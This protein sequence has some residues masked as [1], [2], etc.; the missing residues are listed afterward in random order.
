MHSSELFCER[1]DG[2]ERKITDLKIYEFLGVHRDGEGYIFRTYQREAVAVELAG[3]FNSWGGWQMKN[4]GYGYW[5]IRVESE[6][7]LE[8]NCYKY[9]IYNEENCELKPDP[10]ARYSQWGSHDASIV[11]FDEYEWEDG[12]WMAERGKSS[13][14]IPLNIYQLHLG[15]WKRREGRSYSEGDAYLN[16]RDVAAAL[17]CY[18]SDMGYTHA[19]FIGVTEEGKELGFAPTA[20]YGRPDGLKLLVDTLHRSNIGVIFRLECEK[21]NDFDPFETEIGAIFNSAS[22]WIEE[23]HVDGLY[24][25]DT[26]STK[27]QREMKERFPTLLL[28][29][30]NDGNK[31]TEGI[32]ADRRWSRDVL[33]YAASDPQY[34]RFKYS[35]INLS[36][37]DGMERH[38]ILPITYSD[39]SKGKQ[40]LIN[41]MRGSY[42][43]KFDRLRLFY[44]YMMTHPGKKLTFMGCE[45]GE[46]KEWSRDEPLEWFLLEQQANKKLKEFVKSLNFLY[47]ESPE[48]WK[49]DSSWRGF[50]WILPLDVQNGI[51]AFKRLDGSGGE[52]IAAL[53]FTDNR[54]RSVEIRAEDVIVERVINSDKREYGGEGRGGVKIKEAKLI[55]SVPPLSAVVVKCSKN[56]KTPF[57]EKAI[58]YSSDV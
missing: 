25:A 53:N 33:D 23:Y 31:E 43:E 12:E 48:L 55:L 34:K 37:T 4:I 8:G 10:Y 2:N 19:G 13:F 51:M 21:V 39:I 44:C 32:L 35:R 52:M 20:R 11:Y 3:D 7:P 28:I 56:K 9:R 57:F 15:T 54:E 50:S 29:F 6:I 58:D 49:N 24:F 41:K 36:L 17:A 5:E 45:F 16:Y 14:D 1:I 38:R 42:G 27:I 22:F 30:E 40:S 47:K 46:D 18:V 26:I